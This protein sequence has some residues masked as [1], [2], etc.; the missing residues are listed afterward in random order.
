MRKIVCILFVSLL[1]AASAHGQGVFLRGAGAINESMGGTATGAPIDALGA[2]QWNPAGIS[3]LEKN[4]ISFAAGLL[5]PTA[6]ISSPQGEIDGQPGT[7]LAPCMGITWREPCSKWT[8]GLGII[9]VGGAKSA[10]PSLKK[11]AGADPTLRELDTLNSDILI[12][13]VAPTVSYQLTEKLSIG[14]APTLTLCQ[15]LCD[16]LYISQ[17]PEGTGPLSFP[18]GSSSRYCYGG[19]FQFGLFYDTKCN[20]Q[21]GLCYK[22]PQW[23]EP[24]RYQTEEYSASG[25]YLGTDVRKLRINLPQT[26]SLGAAYT[27]FDKTLI[28]LDL[29]YFS[30]AS[31]GD[32]T[33]L[34][35][36]DVFGFNLGIQRILTDRITGRIGYAYNQNPISDAYTYRN[37]A[38]SMITEHTLFMGTTLKI[39]QQIDLSLTYAH[40]FSNEISGASP[41]GMP[42]KESLSADSINLGIRVTF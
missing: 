30:Y 17:A 13:Q 37:L 2:L 16:P 26:I 4:E 21:F 12:L 41:L 40:A 23:M 14:A 11:I 39:T 29:R 20:W 6:S 9:S 15:L 19:G 33:K 18:S 22:S 5:L 10:F 42:I 27:G 31:A 36:R 8:Y 7:A 28:A 34:G 38:S 1:F 24:F 32:F 3:A 35:W 25:E